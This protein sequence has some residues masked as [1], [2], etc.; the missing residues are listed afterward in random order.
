MW[1]NKRRALEP[2]YAGYRNC[3]PSHHNARISD[4]TPMGLWRALL[5]LTAFLFALAGVTTSAGALTTPARYVVLMD[6]QTGTVL[7][8]KN[9][10]E[11][12]SPA[13]MSKIMTLLLAFEALKKED[14]SL[15]ETL[16]I[17]E[18]AWRK[19]GAKSGSSTMFA[20]VGSQIPVEDILH[21]I[22]V[23]S[24]NDASIALAEFLS[25]SEGNF[26][27]EMTHRARALGLEKS[28]FAN[29]TGWP[30]PKHVMTPYEIAL[31]ARHIIMNHEDFYPYFAKKS[32]M[33]NGINQRNRNTLIGQSLN[34]IT[35]DGL[36]TGY[37]KKSGYGMVV[38]ATQDGRRLILV[39]SGLSSA[40][41]RATEA[42]RFIQWGFR[43][44]KPYQ[45]FKKTDVITHIPVWH[46]DVAK[47]AVKAE[48]DVIAIMPRWARRNMV[49]QVS[50]DAPRKAPLKAGALVGELTI[51][52]P[53][54]INQKV[55]LIAAED[56]R[57]ESFF[58]RILSSIAYYLFS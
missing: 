35:V 54:N 51:T 5:S 3:K 44:F 58:L 6:G 47:V 23:S 14:I 40:K 37:T 2:Q 32:F 10:D 19:G 45:L 1:K 52:A 36:K 56:V 9:G 29:A 49:V 20:K 53:E 12:I 33:W 13:S 55:A 7:Y 18:N 38:S 43:Y 27:A 11:I 46:G 24:G 15:Q 21:G 30:N 50:Y 16:P 26:A 39:L 22:I 25:G 34:G 57:E 17:S 48:K 42:R 4:G 41:A 28:T 31:L 8:Q